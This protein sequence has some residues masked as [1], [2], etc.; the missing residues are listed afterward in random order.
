MNLISIIALS[1]VIPAAFS[2]P[3]PSDA[4]DERVVEARAVL[5]T[6]SSGNTYVERFQTSTMAWYVAN[7][8]AGFKPT[9][10]A[11]PDC[12]FQISRRSTL[13][14]AKLVR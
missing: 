4:G 7:C 5:Q 8:I 11:V 9:L 1:A 14:V 13:G 10:S 2:H 6:T 12:K 3:I